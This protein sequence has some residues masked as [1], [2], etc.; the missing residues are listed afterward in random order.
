[1]TRKFNINDHLNLNFKDN[2]LLLEKDKIIIDKTCPHCKKLLIEEKEFCDCGFFLKARKNSIIFGYIF[3][4]WLI[5]GF[6]LLISLFGFQKIK[7]YTVQAM[8]KKGTGIN[9]LSPV[10]VQI[11]SSLKN[12]SFDNYI[13]NIYVKPGEENKLMILIKPNLWNTLTKKEKQELIDQVYKNWVVVY[14]QKY[15]DL[16]EK[17]EVLFAN[18]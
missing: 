3:S 11:I 14:R 10:N 5:V 15:P 9:S 4:I 13:Q 6:L 1:M 17:P 12:S 7:S 16:K 2:Y 18:N 8:H